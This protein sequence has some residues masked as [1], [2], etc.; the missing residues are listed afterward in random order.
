MSGECP[1]IP[2]YVTAAATTGSSP[3]A[4]ASTRAC[5]RTRYDEEQLSSDLALVRTSSEGRIRSNGRPP[6]DAVQMRAAEP[7]RVFCV[8]Y[9][10]N[11]ERRTDNAGPIVAMKDIGHYWSV[12]RQEEKPFLFLLAKSLPLVVGSSRFSFRRGT[13][14]LYLASTNLSV[15]LWLYPQRRVEEETALAG[16]VQPGDHVIDIGANIGNITLALAKR[17]GP[18]GRVYAFEPHP[19]TFRILQA[20]AKLNGASNVQLYNYAAAENEQALAIESRSSDDMNSIVL[21]GD[22]TEVFARRIDSLIPP[23]DKIRLLKIDV[24]GYELFALQGCAGVLPRV[25]MVWFECSEVQCLKYGYAPADL[26]HFIRQAGFEVWDPAAHRR[27]EASDA[28]PRKV[29]NLLAIRSVLV[30]TVPWP[31]Q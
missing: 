26:L 10:A 12:L 23:G 11:D 20:N 8:R 4:L 6:R 29:T 28:P 25:D 9:F 31:C 22:G 15:Q 16:L 21:A 1:R 14:R 2:N 30:A 24:E 27:I 17:V 3:P 13:Y 7:G 18:K 19:R 5:W